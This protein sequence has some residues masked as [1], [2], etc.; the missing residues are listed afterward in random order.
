VNFVPLPEIFY[1]RSAK[2][3]A[4]QLLGHFLIR[5]TAAGLCGGIIVETE[6]YLRNDPACHASRGETARNKPMFG[7]PGH[8]YVYFIYGNHWCFNAVTNRVGIGEAVLVRAIEPFF[9]EEFMRTNRI[10]SKR[11][12]LT[13]G[14]AK[15]CEAMKI[16]RDLNH[17]NLCETKSPVFIAENPERKSFLKERGVIVTTTRIGIT[18]AANLP[19]RFYVDGSEFVSRR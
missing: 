13:N 19:L 11:R 1:A 3:V 6:A 9:G 5:Q 16:D 4:R 15:F 18:L 12:D 17:A 7:P 14:P 2:I 8:A 10:V